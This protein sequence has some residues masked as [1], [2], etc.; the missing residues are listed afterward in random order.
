[1][2]KHILLWLGLI[3]VVILAAPALVPSNVIMQR[4]NAEVQMIVAA[5][6]AQQAKLVID[7][8]NREYDAIFVRSGIVATASKAYIP[9]DT[10]ASSTRYF[11]WVRSLAGATNGYLLA[12]AG[13][14]YSLLVR[15]HLLAEW[16]PFI[17][18]FLLAAVVD[19]MVRRR[20][21]FAT[22]GLISPMALGVAVHSA[23]I[24]AFLPIVYLIAPFPITP[25]F[26]PFW[27]L[28]IAAPIMLIMAN[29]Q[30]IRG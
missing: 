9:E 20:I 11:P 4:I 7:Q 6:G 2:G 12:L 21:K 30:R 8:A 16:V 10:Q 5:F 15:I 24:L 28:L 18:P 17:A 22:F 1:M 27:A 25:L 26:V 13:T 14:C 19:G 29:I 3:A 23:I